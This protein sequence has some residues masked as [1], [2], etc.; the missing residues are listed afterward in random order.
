MN[1]SNKF[2]KE[3][4][5]PDRT[6][7]K[8]RTG[9]L[10]FIDAKVDTRDYCTENINELIPNQKLKR[11]CF[12]ERKCKLRLFFSSTIGRVQH[13]QLRTYL[14]ECFYSS[15]G[16]FLVL[17]VIIGVAL[18]GT[19]FSIFK[20]NQEIPDDI[21]PLLASSLAMHRSSCILWLSKAEF[22]RG[23]RKIRD[24]WTPGNLNYGTR[25]PGEMLIFTVVFCYSVIAPIFFSFVVLYFGVGWL[26]LR[27]Q[28]L[29]VFIP[30]F[31]SYGQMW[32]HIH[33]HFVA[34][35][36]LF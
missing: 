32:P 28:V 25:I 4:G 1:S 2:V 6:R 35:L 29:K 13:L 16:K 9:L 17:N 24:A 34:A 7:P 15:L 5:K 8:N 19:L 26:V 20:T 33:T 30:S 22:S 36:V 10:G 11:K 12:S 21:I 14:P 18:G 27:N 23:S 31:K 3:K